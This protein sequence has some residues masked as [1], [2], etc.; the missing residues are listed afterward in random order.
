MKLVGETG[1]LRTSVS[2]IALLFFSSVAG[3]EETEVS[4]ADICGGAEIG[5]VVGDL[6]DGEP[7]SDDGT[8][9][10]DDGWSDPGEDG[11]IDPGEGDGDGGTDPGEG[12]GDGGTDPGEGDGDDGT[13]PGEGEGEVVDPGDGEVVD[14]GEGGWTDPDEG[15]LVDPVVTEWPTAEDGEFLPEMVYTMAD[16]TAGGPEVQ[17]GTAA[18]PVPAAGQGRAAAAIPDQCGFGGPGLFGLCRKNAP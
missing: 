6:G 15:V 3:A 7:G 18:M 12:D 8:I 17:R 1:R 11:E 13:D 10:I 5:V 14:P 9:T 4:C 2:V 16:G